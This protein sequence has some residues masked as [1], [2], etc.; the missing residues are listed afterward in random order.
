MFKSTE[1]ILRN[2]PR[3]SNFYIYIFRFKV[4]YINSRIVHFFFTIG[5]LM[6]GLSATQGKVLLIGDVVRP[7]R[8]GAKVVYFEN[9]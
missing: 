1:S 7:Y 6:Q 2:C 9:M 5:H 8:E 4:H 3:K